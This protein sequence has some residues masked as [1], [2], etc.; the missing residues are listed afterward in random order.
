M[1]SNAAQPVCIDQPRNDVE[2]A[3]TTSLVA[4]AAGPFVTGAVMPP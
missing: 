2:A 4:L 3:F 1:L